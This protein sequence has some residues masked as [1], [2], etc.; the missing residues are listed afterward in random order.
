MGLSI[1]VNCC[2]FQKY[3]HRQVSIQLLTLTEYFLGLGTADSEINKQ[4]EHET[5]TR[6]GIIYI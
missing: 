2:S 4:I 1:P 3:T 6:V 5:E